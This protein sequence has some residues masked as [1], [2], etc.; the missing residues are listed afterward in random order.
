MGRLMGRICEELVE[1]KEYAQTAVHENFF[2]RK[3]S[4][5]VKRHGRIQQA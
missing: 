2:N 3:K 1:N 5:I 4:I